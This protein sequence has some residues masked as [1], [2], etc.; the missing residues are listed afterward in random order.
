MVKAGMSPAQAIR[1]PTSDA[2]RL[3]GRQDRIGA[4]EPRKYPD[5]AAVSGDPLN[6]ITVLEKVSFVMRVARSLRRA[7]SSALLIG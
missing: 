6:D 5:I 4:S 7:D 2:A 3:L 1:A